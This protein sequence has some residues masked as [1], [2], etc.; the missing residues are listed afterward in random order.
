MCLFR[1]SPPERKPERGYV[2]MFSRNKNGNESTFAK[3]TL[4]EN[5]PLSPSEKSLVNG[6]ARFWC[7]QFQS[8]TLETV[9][10]A[11]FL[12]REGISIYHSA[13]PLISIA[14]G[15]G[16]ICSLLTLLEIA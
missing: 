4:L 11:R 8:F 9:Y 3:T 10:S 7:T 6:D 15:M 2:R 14:L 13:F 12:C 5:H 16:A 1:M